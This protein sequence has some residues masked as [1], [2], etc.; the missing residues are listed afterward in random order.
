MMLKKYHLVNVYD[1]FENGEILETTM[2]N[3]NI[4]YITRTKHIFKDYTTYSFNS[5]L[6]NGLVCL[7]MVPD[8]PFSM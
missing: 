1:D 8:K 2:E 4:K 5:H 6:Y 3:K 7:G